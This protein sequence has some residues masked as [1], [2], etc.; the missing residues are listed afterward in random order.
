[1]ASHL[2]ESLEERIHQP[3][4]LLQSLAAHVLPLAVELAPRLV[5][6]P[7]ALGAPLAHRRLL[8]GELQRRRA[9]RL[10][11]GDALEQ[12]GAKSEALRR[13]LVPPL[14]RLARHRVHLRQLGVQSTLLLRRAHIGVE[15]GR[16]GGEEA[17]EALGHRREL[18]VDRAE[19]GG[20]RPQRVGVRGQLA[21]GLVAQHRPLVELALRELAVLEEVGVVVRRREVGDVDLPLR[22]RRRR[23]LGH[24]A[25]REQVVPLLDAVVARLRV[26]LVD[27]KTV[28]LP[29]S[30]R[31]IASS[32]TE[33]YGRAEL[34]T[35]LLR[36]V[37]SVVSRAVSSTT[38]G[39]IVG[40]S[41]SGG[42]SWSD[43]RGREIGGTPPAAALSRRAT[44]TPT[45]RARRRPRGSPRASSRPWL[46][47]VAQ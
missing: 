22:P 24:L 45:P 20:R 26:V 40:D 28:S 13:H 9:A 14:D 33:P 41:S 5:P 42:G 10:V 21:V 15:G 12:F 4:H 18:E 32:R 37:I 8:L 19:L 23:R 11:G 7:H 46:R 16:E 27:L 38:G 34:V 47:V 1:M 39:S 35:E 3:P 29:W 36:G 31:W 44:G 2:R 6:L 25:V 43:G 17:A 30:A